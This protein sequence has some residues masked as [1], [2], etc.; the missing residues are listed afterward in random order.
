VQVLLANGEECRIET[1]DSQAGELY[2]IAMDQSILLCL[3]NTPALLRLI[4]TGRVFPA[5][6]LTGLPVKYLA[7]WKNT[8]MSCL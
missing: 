2:K 8:F 4:S 5:Y 6:H 1:Y 3:N 7:E